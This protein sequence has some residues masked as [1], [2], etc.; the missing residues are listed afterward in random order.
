ML[1]S[2]CG[3]HCCR[4]P[5]NPPGEFCRVR[6]SEILESRDAE[7]CSGDARGHALAVGWGVSQQH[8]RALLLPTASKSTRDAFPWGLGRCGDLWWGR[9][10]LALAATGEGLL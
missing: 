8:H 2:S 1:G 6:G 5:L 7:P 4:T 10:L 9:A 3:T